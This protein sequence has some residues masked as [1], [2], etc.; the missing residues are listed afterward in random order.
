MSRIQQMTREL[1]RLLRYLEITPNIHPVVLKKMDDRVEQHISD[2]EEMITKN[3][4]FQQHHINA[5]KKIR[6][7]HNNIVRL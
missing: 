4:G 7:K 5:V 1:E 2:L 6:I 3:N